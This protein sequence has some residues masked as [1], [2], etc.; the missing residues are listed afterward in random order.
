MQP[1][2]T[3]DAGGAIHP[4]ESPE[5]REDDEHIV[6]VP[7]RSL[8]SDPEQSLKTLP[9][10]KWAAPGQR[11]SGKDLVGA[12]C[13]HNGSSIEQVEQFEGL[14]SS[15]SPGERIDIEDGVI[16]V[17]DRVLSQTSDR[18]AKRWIG[19]APP[20]AECG[21]VDPFL[22]QLGPGD[23]IGQKGPLDHRV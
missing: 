9:I 14:Q 4:V 20:L 3:F 16:A 15:Q 1:E 19:V 7:E 6:R 5:R 21:A 18:P 17:G 8:E 13:F 22:L 23:P 2:H 11:V 10:G 12:Q